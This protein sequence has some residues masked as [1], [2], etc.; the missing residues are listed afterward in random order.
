MGA[1]A[2]SSPVLRQL[3]DMD[4]REAVAIFVDQGIVRRD[5]RTVT[6]RVRGLDADALVDGDTVAML[7]EGLGPG[8]RAEIRPA[9]A[10]R[11][12]RRTTPAFRDG[13]NEFDGSSYGS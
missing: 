8:G 13:K 1:G 10:R 12:S 11:T 7:V 3:Q 9:S 5:A 4:E 6:A 2:L